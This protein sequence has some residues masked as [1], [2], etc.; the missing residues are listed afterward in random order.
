MALLRSLFDQREHLACDVA[1]QASDG[2]EL[3]MAFGN[4]LCD[5]SLRARVSPEPTDGD[6]VQRAVGGA[7][8]APAEPMA[9]CLAG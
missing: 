4:T 7:V 2:F 9:R 5:I 3:G 6:D 1:L 8:T